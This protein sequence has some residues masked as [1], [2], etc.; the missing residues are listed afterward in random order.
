M[1]RKMKTRSTETIK[2]YS[3]RSRARTLTVVLLIVAVIAGIFAGVNLFTGDT[4]GKIMAP[5]PIS[6][7]YGSEVIG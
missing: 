2:S 5:G 4:D 1:E 6:S 7:P 3:N